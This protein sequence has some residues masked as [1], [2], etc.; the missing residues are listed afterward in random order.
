[1]YGAECAKEQKSHL[2]TRGKVS[3]THPGELSTHPGE[4]STHPG[5]PSTHPGKPSTHPGEGFDPPGGIICPPGGK[6]QRP[7]RAGEP[8][9]HPGEL[10]LVHP[11]EPASRPMTEAARAG[12]ILRALYYNFQYYHLLLFFIFLSSRLFAS[13]HP[14]PSPPHVPPSS[15]PHPGE[16]LAGFRQPLS[17]PTLRPV[18]DQQ[19]SK[20][21]LPDISRTWQVRLTLRS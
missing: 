9:T 8:S 15:P 4:P 5:K 13:P 12:L 7:T 21:Y 1:M 20:R 17:A 11:G 16:S 10:G 18:L 3:K 6:S 14:I 2:P 19:P